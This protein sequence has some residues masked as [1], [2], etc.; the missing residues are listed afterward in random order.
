MSQM[1]PGQAPDLPG[2][3]VIPQ[4]QASSGEAHFQLALNDR[5]RFLVI[6]TRL[7]DSLLDRFCGEHMER[8]GHLLFVGPADH[9]NAIGLR[10]ALPLLKPRPLGLQT[11]AGMGDR[12]GLATPGHVRAAR[13]VERSPGKRALGFI[14]AQQSVREMSRADRSP[15]EVLDDATWGA[16]QEGWRGPSGADAD[17]L[18]TLADVE[19]CASAGYTLFTLDPGDYVEGGADTLDESAVRARYEA[20]P[21]EELDSSPIG[22]LDYYASR[23]FDLEDRGFTLDEETLMRAAVKYGRAIAHVA[24]LHR[25]LAASRPSAGFELEISVDE[26]HSPTSHAEH[27]YIASELAR[28]R[29]SWVSLAPRFVGRF[30]KGVD[31]LGDLG[32]FER[33]FAGHA[34]IAR[35]LGPYKLSLH[36]AS[37]KFSIYGIAA[38]HARGL[39]HLKTAGTS[40]LEALRV[41]AHRAPDLFRQVYDVAT[42]CYEIDRVSYHVSAELRRV[43]PSSSLSDAELPASIDFFDTRQVLHVTFGSVMAPERGL[44][45]PLLG[46]LRRYAADYDTGLERHFV[47]HLAPLAA[48]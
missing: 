11:S 16:F 48:V 24:D 35:C 15:E 40:Y 14:F 41:V 20:L 43:P 25:H 2:L 32:E 12:L 1:I 38:E 33:D 30:E 39:L 5:G 34:S 8:D 28:L 44:R 13:G 45:T 18:K 17:H 29:V 7:G 31:Y 3:Q 26:T 4:S 46:T 36:S 9:A 27:C 37:D 19:R 6:L 23:R 22:L 21:W 42:E 10:E 47:R